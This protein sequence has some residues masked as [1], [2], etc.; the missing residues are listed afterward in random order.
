MRLV[1]LALLAAIAFTAHAQDNIVMK[2]GDEIKAKVV[3]ITVGEIKYKKFDNLDGPIYTSPK[4]DVVFVKYA[5]GSK[6]VF[7]ISDTVVKSVVML[8]PKADLTMLNKGIAD[9]DEHFRAGGLGF[10]TFFVTV[11]GTPLLGLIPAIVGSTTKPNPENL[12]F[13]D[14][15]LA[16]DPDYNKG[17]IQKAMQKKRKAAWV[18]FAMGT[19]ID[20]ILIPTIVTVK[21]AK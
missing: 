3:E 6:E 8:P 7:A 18:G 19:V 2:N 10:G 12:K 4:T 14:A 5:N 20:A 15:K 13:P 1:V 21:A 9:A 11:I 17:Y 16:L